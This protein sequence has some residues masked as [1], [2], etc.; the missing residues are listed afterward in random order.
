MPVYEFYCAD[1]HTIF[2]FLARLVNPDKRPACPR[3]GR[4]ELERRVSRFAISKNRPEDEADGLPA[5]MDEERMEQAM[6]A[7]AGEMEGANADDPRA[8]ARF[9]RKFSEMSGMPLGDEA[10]EAMRR[11]EAGDD[12]EQI[13]AEMGDLFGDAG[14]LDGLFGQGRLAGI[15]RRLAPPEHD[16]TLYPL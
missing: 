15:K 1:C 16:E 3:C 10:Q 11:L 4:P 2:N 9:L 7:L 13:E 14:N 6:L 5:G 8:L 12:P